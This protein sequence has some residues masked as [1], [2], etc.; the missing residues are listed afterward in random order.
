MR[1]HPDNICPE[2][3]SIPCTDECGVECEC[4]EDYHE[5]CTAD[6]CECSLHGDLG[7]DPADIIEARE[8]AAE[9]AWENIP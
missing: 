2:C 6:E 9:H 1:Y 4:D 7:P 8:W 3:Y 5:D